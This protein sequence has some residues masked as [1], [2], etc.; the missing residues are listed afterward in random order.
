[1]IFMLSSKFDLQRVGAMAA[2]PPAFSTR[3]EYTW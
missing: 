3:D 1:M 2:L